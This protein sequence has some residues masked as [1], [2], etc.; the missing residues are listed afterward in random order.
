MIKLIPGKLY[1]FHAKGKSF[2]GVFTLTRNLIRHLEDK[3]VFMFLQHKT[4]V[5]LLILTRE[6]KIYGVEL[7][8]LELVSLEQIC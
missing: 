6:A 7:Y 8:L 1:R 5:E 3:E 2:P 4:Q